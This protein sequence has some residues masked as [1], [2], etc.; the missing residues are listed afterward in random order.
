MVTQ[1]TSATFQINNAKLY[2]PAV[3]LSINDNIKFLENIKQGLERKIYWNKYRSGITTRPK[4]NNLDDSID[5]AFRNINRLFV[6]SFKNSNNNPKRSSFDKDYMPLEEIKAF[7]ALLIDN[8][9]SFDQPIKNKQEVYVEMSR[10]DL[11]TTGNLLDYLYHEKY[12]KVIG[13]DL[14]RQTNTNTPQQIDFVGKLGEDHGATNF[15]IDEK[16]QKTILNFFLDLI[17]ITE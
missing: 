10:N 9:P 8:K 16:E 2:V 5:R 13:I 7:N 11:Y 12:N 15:F 1:I 6:L 17:I 3:T 14:S 4:N